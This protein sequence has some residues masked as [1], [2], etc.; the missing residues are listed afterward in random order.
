V[1]TA[2]R[3]GSMLEHGNAALS[4]ELIKKE[5]GVYGF[6]SPD[7]F[8]DR[9]RLYSDLLL[10]WNERIKLT[11]VTDKIQILRFHFGESLFA[12]SACGIQKGRLADFGSG[13]GF[14]GGP[15]AMALPALTVVLIEANKRKAA[16]LA[17]L[18]RT[19]KL[20]N[21]AV[22]AGRAE[23]LSPAEKFDFVTARAVGNY[24]SLLDW[25]R[26]RLARDGCVVLWLGAKDVQKVR[27]E[28]GWAW[29]DPVQIPAT[30][31]RFV[32]YGSVA[33]G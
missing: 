21:A 13:A 3:P 11:T 15:L 2:Q 33:A 26:P 9:V 23:A 17:E 31:E 8:A 28:G 14:P 27:D 19:I 22:H 1:G 30:R 5:L 29:Q 24:S 20:A 18:K 12:I 7:D 25:A 6:Q 32:L 4:L 10:R 16:F